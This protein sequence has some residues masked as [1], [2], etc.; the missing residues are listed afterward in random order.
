VRKLTILLVGAVLGSLGVINAFAQTPPVLKQSP[1]SANPASDTLTL[2]EEEPEIDEDD[3][4]RVNTSLI[5]VPAEVMDRDGRYV[6]NLGR[7]DFRIFEN[8][9]EQKLA[10]FASVQQ[11]FTLA[12]LLD[13]SGSTQSQ[14]HAIRSAANTFIRGLRG[15]DR[16]LIIS[17]DG[18]V[19]LLTEAITLIELRG[20]TFRLDA[21][22]DGTVLYDAVDG[23]LKRL[24]PISGRKAVVLLTDGVDFGSKLSTLK[25]NIRDAEESNVI[26]Y[27][28]QYNTVPQF[29]QRLS[30]IA[31]T[32]AREK[33]QAKME[34]E[35]R[36]GSLYLRDLAE[37][38]GGTIYNA[39]T[40]A[41]VPGAFRGI[42]EQL[43]RQYSLGYYPTAQA[44]AGE[45]RE[46]RVKLRKSN[47]VVRARENYIVKANEP[48]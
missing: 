27:P 16:I 15:N 35:Y 13:V 21:L 6:A 32:K 20:K 12:L 44:R 24:A 34:R 29:P 37:K 25:Q 9:K 39:D 40:L 41:D 45:K 10:Y 33:L 17:F 5:T 19:N 42:T 3:V 46:I 23:V 22:N 36:Q 11:P 28:V 30:R 18:K 48:R 26:I 14:L 2:T 8:G 38:T 1:A 43:G 47:L 7:Q 4:V 31:S